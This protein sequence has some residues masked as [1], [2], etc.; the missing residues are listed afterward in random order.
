MAAVGTCD[1]AGAG[2]GT[3]DDDHGGDTSPT[4]C[5]GTALTDAV[6]G[7]RS[8]GKVPVRC[9][10]RQERNFNEAVFLRSGKTN[11]APLRH[12]ATGEAMVPGEPCRGS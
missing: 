10:R 7:D 1:G 3:C 12:G 5:D 8:E 6:C 11:Q 2:G 9:G 4:G